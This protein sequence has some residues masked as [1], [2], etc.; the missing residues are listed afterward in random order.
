MLKSVKIRDGHDNFFTPLRLIFATIVV[1]GH[2]FAVALRDP[3]AEPQVFLHYN[4]SYIAVNLFFIAS[5]FLVTKSMLYRGDVSNYAAARALR[6]YPALIVHV[7]FVMIF[8]GLLATNLPWREFLTHPDLLKQP[9]LVL[10]F[11]ETNMV[12][13]GAFLENG[14]QLG[15]AP[16]W[17]LR[18]EVLA[19]IGTAIVFMLGLLKRKWMV[20]AQFIVPSILWLVTHQLGLFESMPGTFQNLLRFG[21]AYGLG[22]TIYAYRDRLKFH[23]LLIPVFFGLTALIAS[24][25]SVEIA[26]NVALGYFLMWAAFVKIPALNSLQKMGDLSYGVY[27]Y[28]WCVL[29]LLF[30]YFPNL[31]SWTLL[32]IALPITFILAKLSWQFVEK[33]MLARKKS[34]SDLMDR[35]RKNKRTFDPKS[36]LLD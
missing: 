6:I 12:M 35:G 19:Y 30:K 1:I 21:I 20:L 24:T 3:G 2:S 28:H 10:S 16:L 5:G 36:V 33:P 29:Q 18:Y 9:L 4:F 25:Q 14:E 27:I 26:M 22:A 32:A 8:I 34:L 7:F 15:S 17:T 11:Y 13:P 31:S 23:P